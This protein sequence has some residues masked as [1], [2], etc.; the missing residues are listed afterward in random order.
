MTFGRVDE[1]IAIGLSALDHC[2]RAGRRLTAM[3][4]R[5]LLCRALATQGDIDAAGLHWRAA[6]DYANEQGLPDR[7]QIETLLYEPV[8]RT[9]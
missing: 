2:E 5:A 7:T 8:K 4:L 1:A 9:A 3:R 6:L